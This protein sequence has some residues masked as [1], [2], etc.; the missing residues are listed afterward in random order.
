MSAATAV[1]RRELIEKRKSILFCLVF[2]CVPVFAPLIATLVTGSRSGSSGLRD[3]LASI[4]AITLFITVS[5][6]GGVTTIGRDLVEQRLS[7]YLARPISTAALWFSKLGAV[8]VVAFAC[9]IAVLIPATL[10]GGGI[11]SLPRFGTLGFD[12]IVI[13]AALGIP[14][15]ALVGHAAGIAV[16]SKSAWLALDVFALGVVGFFLWTFL[17]VLIITLGGRLGLALFAALTIVLFL[18]LAAAGH[19]QLEYGRTDIRAG[20]RAMSLTLWI[21]V[22]VFVGG[23]TAYLA[24]LDTGSP[25]DLNRVMVEKVSPRGDWM[26]V[27][28]PRHLGLDYGA[29]FLFNPSTG[30]SVS[31][32]ALS[33]SVFSPDGSTAAVVQ[34]SLVMPDSVVASLSVA[35]LDSKPVRLVQ[36]DIAFPGYPP[37]LGLSRDGSRLATFDSHTISV[38]DLAQQKT[39]MSATVSQESLFRAARLHFLG[40]EI[41]RCYAAGGPRGNSLHV[42]ELNLRTRKAREL[43][44][45]AITHGNDFRVTSDGTAILSGA[46]LFDVTTGALLRTLGSDEKSKSDILA[47]GRIVVTRTGSGRS[48]LELFDRSG[49]PIRT[50]ALPATSSIRIAGEPEAGQVLL[51]PE[52]DE[53]WVVDLDAGTWQRIVTRG[54]LTGAGLWN[55]R[56]DASTPLAPGSIA[57]RLVMRSDGSLVEVDPATGR[58]RVIVK[59]RM[60]S[61]GRKS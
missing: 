47:D 53:A 3:I 51:Q 12:E 58:E 56:S 34:F 50:I 22:L 57:T 18:A 49:T 8:L 46:K 2:G 48:E 10:V 59:G 33:G 5:F 1:F 35:K 37:T 41:V 14:F 31:L 30:E 29:S 21:P 4:L 27:G 61:D 19:A 60:R 25:A 26:Q 40:D 28:G 45:I 24:W 38:I 54:T 11:L 13:A 43:A 23:A 55:Q 52:M 36:K 39:L 44:V 15:V 7:F 17:R 20:H 42:F 32:G 6:L 16:R 9:G